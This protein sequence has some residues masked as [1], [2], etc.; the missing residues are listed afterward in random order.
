MK[1]TL[2]LLMITLLVLFNSAC[3]SSAKFACTDGAV[4]NFF[5]GRCMA[6][7]DGTPVGSTRPI[8]APNLCTPACG[9]YPGCLTR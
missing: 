9:N 2:L 7:A 4:F 3:P 5:Y 1:K 6:I 8:C